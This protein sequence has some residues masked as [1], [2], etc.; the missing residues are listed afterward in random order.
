MLDSSWTGAVGGEQ[1][2]MALGALA[3]P[4]WGCRAEAPLFSLGLS[5]EVSPSLPVS[6]ISP[7]L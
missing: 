4:S 3:L 7:R 1:A 5:L 2:G 6:W